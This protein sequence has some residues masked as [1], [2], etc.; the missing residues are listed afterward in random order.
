MFSVSEEPTGVRRREEGLP[1]GRASNLR[2]E[3]PVECSQA[4]GKRENVLDK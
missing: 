2:P 3:G 4:K 1:G